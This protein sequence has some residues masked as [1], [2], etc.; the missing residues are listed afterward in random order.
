MEVRLDNVH[1]SNRTHLV[2]YIVRDHCSGLFFADISPSNKMPSL[3]KFLMSAW[4][5]KEDY[6][7]CGI[8]ELMMI[9]KTVETFFPDII[10]SINSLGISLVKVTSG[11][12]GGIINTKSVENWLKLSCDKPVETA[13]I[14]AH[15]ISII[16]AKE[17]SRNGVDDK[18]SLWEKHVNDL[19]Y[20]PADWGRKA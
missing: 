10:Q 9:P 13:S 7:F 15:H 5:K 4:G 19:R 6:S 17:K 2:H 8:P 18:I 16:M 3:E 11:F 1:A 14:E 20:P 12:Q